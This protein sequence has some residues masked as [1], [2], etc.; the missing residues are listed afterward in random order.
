MADQFADFNVT[1]KVDDD[2]RL[3]AKEHFLD[4]AAIAHVTALERAPADG[5]VVFLFQ[6]VQ[7]DRLRTRLGQRLADMAADVTGAAGDEHRTINRKQ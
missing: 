6:R 3:V 4:E 1:S 7:A 5:P 2:L